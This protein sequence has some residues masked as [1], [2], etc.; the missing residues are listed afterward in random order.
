M[1][2]HYVQDDTG[3]VWINKVDLLAWLRGE[4]S[5]RTSAEFREYAGVLATAIDK[6]CPSNQEGLSS[7]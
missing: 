1:V 2:I 5:E 3:R 4:G 7:P 6:A